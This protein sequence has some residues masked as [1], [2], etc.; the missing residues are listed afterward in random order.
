[1]LRTTT[2]LLRRA[3]GYENR[4]MYYAYR[5]QRIRYLPQKL[6]H[7]K[8][9]LA[10]KS[11]PEEFGNTWDQRTGP[12][13][14]Y[15]MRNRNEYRHWPWVTWKDDPVGTGAHALSLVPSRSFSAKNDTLGGVNSDAAVSRS[16]QLYRLVGE[17]Y[18]VPNH[19]PVTCM[20]P[21][22][23]RYT[24]KVWS[25]TELVR[26]LE[27]LEANGWTTIQEVVEQFEKISAWNDR[28]HS[29]PRSL[30]VHVQK[31]G[32]DMIRQNAQKQFRSEMQSKGYLRTN[33]MVR[34]FALPYLRTGPAMPTTLE[35]PSG[36]YPAGVYR[37]MNGGM[38]KIHRAYT[39]DQKHGAAMYPY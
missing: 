25:K 39:L 2:G 21:F 13:W 1:M 8:S 26:H 11:N 23:A 34:Y 7:A 5:R 10:N 22:I 19:Y 30:L 38:V 31:L 3:R 28:C 20:A 12:E 37:Q 29:I 6:A 9:P 16:A 27:K 36:V 35:Q 15:R 4:I 18:R 33:E 17:H 14:M 24:N 32:T